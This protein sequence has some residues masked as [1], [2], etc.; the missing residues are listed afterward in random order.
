VGSNPTPRAYLRVLYQNNK[1][2]KAKNCNCK[3]HLSKTSPKMQ[4]LSPRK[5]SN[6]LHKITKETVYENINSLTNTCSK[7]Y[8][9]QILKKLAS[10]SLANANIICDYI[11]AEQ[12]ELN[13]KNSTKEGKIKTLVWLSNFFDNKIIFRQLSNQKSS[14]GSN[15]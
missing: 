9:S 14:D 4:G 5:D 7:P 11:I 2:E 6:S 3:G 12:N 13:I 1:S 8:F 15:S 10:E